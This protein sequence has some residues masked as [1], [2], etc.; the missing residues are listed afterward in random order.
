[1]NHSSADR[2]LFLYFDRL[3]ATTNRAPFSAKKNSAKISLRK[4]VQAIHLQSDCMNHVDRTKRWSRLPRWRDEARPQSPH[5]RIPPVVCIATRDPNDPPAS[6]STKTPSRKQLAPRRGM[7]RRLRRH[8]H[9]LGS[10]EHMK[11]I[12]AQ[13][14]KH[15]QLPGRKCSLTE[16]TPRM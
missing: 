15:E 8:R 10:S 16:C 11:R 7:G 3:L 2:M 4:C 1:L 13:N 5:R 9:L 12:Q 6:L 14:T